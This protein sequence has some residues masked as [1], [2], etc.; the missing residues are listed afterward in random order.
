MELG[1]FYSPKGVVS[2]RV[3]VKRTGYLGTISSNQNINVNRRPGS[4]SDIVKY[5]TS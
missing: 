5:L 4:Y 1:V 3:S 2:P